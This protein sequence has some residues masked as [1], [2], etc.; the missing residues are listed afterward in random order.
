MPV[1][2]GLEA[3]FRIREEERKAAKTTIWGSCGS[4]QRRQS[5]ACRSSHKNTCVPIWAI[6]AC[7]DAEQW[8]SPVLAYLEDDK[9]KGR[10][11]RLRA[12]WKGSQ[13][14]L[15]LISVESEY[16]NLPPMSV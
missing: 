10:Q 5:D 15:I 1:M 12:A 14:L 7:C 6:S 3:T 13:Q 8:H 11:A 9:Q 2:D 16:Y 4:A